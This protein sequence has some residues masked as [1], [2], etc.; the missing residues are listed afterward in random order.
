MKNLFLELFRKHSYSLSELTL[1]CVLHDDRKVHHVAS[2]FSSE[3]ARDRNVRLVPQD[4]PHHAIPGPVLQLS[5]P[6]V[7]NRPDLHQDSLDCRAVRRS[8][9]WL[10]WR[11]RS[12]LP[13]GEPSTRLHRTG[14]LWPAWRSRVS[15]P[16]PSAVSVCLNS[17][18]HLNIAMS[19]LHLLASSERRAAPSLRWPWGRPRWGQTWAPACPVARPAC[20]G[21][22]S[23]RR[24]CWTYRPPSHRT[25]NYKVCRKRSRNMYYFFSTLMTFLRSKEGSGL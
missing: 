24:S 12:L 16:D 19:V 4:H 14:G 17:E 25:H 20:R 1:L 15:R 3:E 13:P 22:G 10:P 5:S 18:C 7:V 9:C 2:V 23:T 6:I 8:V 11:M 21:R